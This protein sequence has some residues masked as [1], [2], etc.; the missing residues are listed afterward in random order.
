MRA[1]AWRSMN[2]IQHSAACKARK[3]GVQESDRE[4]FL[5]REIQSEAIRILLPVSEVD[6]EPTRPHSRPRCNLVSPSFPG[7]PRAPDCAHRCRSRCPVATAPSVPGR[8]RRR[9]RRDRLPLGSV[10]EGHFLEVLRRR[11]TRC[12]PAVPAGPRTRRLLPLP[13]RVPGP[14][15]PA[16]DLEPTG[17]E[18]AARDARPQSD[19]PARRDPLRC[20]LEYRLE[21]ELE[22]KFLNALRAGPELRRA[23][24]WEEKIQDGEI[25]WVLRTEE[26]A[27]EIS[28]AGRP[29][30]SQ[31]VMPSSRPDFLIRPANADPAI[32]SVAVFCDGLAFHACQRGTRDGSRTIFANGGDSSVGKYASGR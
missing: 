28:S 20:Q 16:A 23:A 1:S 11:S 19:D 6:L 17:P 4:V 10:A 15:R 5:Y 18:A 25:R 21:S 7:R 24:S 9:A 14:A 30:A 32:R 2:A 31:G 22:T 13:V 29:R 12:R 26:R 27:W 3:A 8:V